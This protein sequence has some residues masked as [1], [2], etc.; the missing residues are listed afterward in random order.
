MRVDDP[1]HGFAVVKNCLVWSKCVSDEGSGSPK[2]VSKEIKRAGAPGYV[3]PVLKEL[4]LYYTDC[5]PWRAN[6]LRTEWTLCWLH[7]STLPPA[8][9]HFLICCS[10][11]LHTKS[12]LHC[13][14]RF[15][16]YAW[17]AIFHIKVTIWNER[18]SRIGKNF[19]FSK[20]STPFMGPSQPPPGLFTWVR[21]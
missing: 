5:T 4:C 20:T 12:P 15:T 11:N 10:T 9:R 14:K 1:I 13:S 16:F 21:W 2:Q 3:K 8:T 19:L 18:I 6:F 7:H 17:F